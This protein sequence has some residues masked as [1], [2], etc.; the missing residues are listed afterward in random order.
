MQEQDAARDEEVT[1]LR[2]LGYK[3]TAI[4]KALSINERSLR[5]W[6]TKVNYQDPLRRLSEEE[7]DETLRE[8]SAN[9]TRP[10]EVDYM[11]L[12]KLKANRSEFDGTKRRLEVEGPMKKKLKGK[13]S[14]ENEKEIDTDS[15]SESD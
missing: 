9:S 8:Y 13:K 1:K 4:S 15:D 2:L 11:N 10:R 3:W 5:K 7:L 6:R 12:A 14:D